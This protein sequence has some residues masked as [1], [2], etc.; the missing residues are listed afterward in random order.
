MQKLQQISMT[1]NYDYESVL[2]GKIEEPRTE[3][4]LLLILSR[5]VSDRQLLYWLPAVRY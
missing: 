1:R 2:K 4:L 3:D 5:Q